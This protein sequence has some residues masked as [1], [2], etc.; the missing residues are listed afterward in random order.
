[1]RAAKIGKKQEYI[2]H[3]NIPDRTYPLHYSLIRFCQK[4]IRQD[5]QSQGKRYSHKKQCK[6]K[7]FFVN[8]FHSPILAEKKLKT[9]KT[10]DKS[11]FARHSI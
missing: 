5:I 9:I 10:L 3:L 7:Q 6:S 11:V 2:Y 4:T 1:L 8:V